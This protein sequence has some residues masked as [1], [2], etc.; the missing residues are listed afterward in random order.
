MFL[1]GAMRL[2]CSRNGAPSCQGSTIGVRGS[3]VRSVAPLWITCTGICG[4]PSS[5][6]EVVAHVLG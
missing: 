2:M 5:R 1:L 4:S 3:V 6:S